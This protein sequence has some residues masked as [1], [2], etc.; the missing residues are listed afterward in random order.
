MPAGGGATF[1]AK[2]H[3]AC[4]SEASVAVATTVVMPTGKIDPLAGSETTETGRAPP[5]TV[6]AGY[7]TA[8]PDAAVAVPL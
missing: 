3:D 2:V 7:A 4:R 6:G 8:V 5:V 1:T